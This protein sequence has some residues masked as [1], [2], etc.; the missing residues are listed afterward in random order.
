MSSNVRKM[1]S[2]EQ[3]TIKILIWRN[4]EYQLFYSWPRTSDPLVKVNSTKCLTASTLLHRI[5]LLSVCLIYPMSG[6]Y[7][8]HWERKG[9]PGSE[10]IQMYYDCL[11]DRQIKSFPSLTNNVVPSAF[12]NKQVRHMSILSVHWYKYD[13]FLT[14]RLWSNCI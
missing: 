6:R 11:C 14:L 7:S 12:A 4:Y 13:I 5:V 3:W 1:S 9:W 2:S 10:E 8:S